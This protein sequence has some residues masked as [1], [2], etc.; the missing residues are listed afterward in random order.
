MGKLPQKYHYHYKNKEENSK[1]IPRQKQTKKVYSHRV[2]MEL[3]L[4]TIKYWTL[5]KGNFILYFAFVFPWKINYLL[6]IEF[7]L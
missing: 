3:P 7:I 6:L 1:C 4:T 5:S 2:G